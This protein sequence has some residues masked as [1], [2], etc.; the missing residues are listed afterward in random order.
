MDSNKKPLILLVDD[1]KEFREIFTLKLESTGCEIAAVSSGAEAIE[2]LRTMKPDL[3]LLDMEMPGMNGI[4]TLE[5]IKE[6]TSTKGVKVAFLTNFGE[7]Q[8]RLEHLDRKF[9]A[10]I[11][12][13]DYIRKT[14]DLDRVVAQIKED[15][16]K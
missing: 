16:T 1:T 9:A 4:E 5:A 2:K 6:S 7:A 3:I 12:A 8:E 10:E 13:V 14:D 11:G 15:L